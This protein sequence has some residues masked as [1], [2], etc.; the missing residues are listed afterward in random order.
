V[1]EVDRG[2]VQRRLPTDLK[3]HVLLVGRLM[4]QVGAETEPSAQPGQRDDDHQPQNR[5]EPE[6]RRRHRGGRMGGPVLV[7]L[8]GLDSVAVNI[9]GLGA[10]V[11]LRHLCGLLARFPFGGSSVVCHVLLLYGA[12]TV[13]A[14][15]FACSSGPTYVPEAGKFPAARAQARNERTMAILLE[16]S[17]RSGVHCASLF[18]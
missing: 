16:Q 3:E 2:E 9:G 15:A 1:F 11:R 18:P 10:G 12:S 7:G 5:G 14:C 6:V 8:V 4:G 17:S 13:S